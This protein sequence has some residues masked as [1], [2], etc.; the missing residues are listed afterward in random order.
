MNI[1]SLQ[2]GISSLNTQHSPNILMQVNNDVLIYKIKSMSF[3]RRRLVSL[4]YADMHVI[5]G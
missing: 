1:G 5:L 3:L 2:T 4:L